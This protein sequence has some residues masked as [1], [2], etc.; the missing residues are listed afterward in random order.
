MKT[1]FSGMAVRRPSISRNR[2]ERI[3]TTLAKERFLHL[4]VLPCVVWLI[5]F[6]YVPMSGLLIAF[7]NYR[8]NTSGFLGIFEAPW[9]GLRNFESFFN[10]IYFTRLMSNTL[11]ISF[12]R[13]IF[14]FPAAILFALLLNEIR[15]VH[16]KKFVQTVSYM[17][18]FLSWVVISALATALLSPDAGAVNGLLQMLGHDKIFFLASEQWFRPVLV[19]SGTWQGIGWSSIVYLAAISG[20]PQEQYESARLDGANKLQQIWYI[21]LPGIKEIIAVMLIMQVGRAMT[22]NFEQVFNMYSPA[23]YKV[24]DIFDT[25][26]YRSGITDANFSYSAAVGLFK[27]VCSLIL[28]LMTN[29]ITN[30]LDAGGLW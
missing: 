5:L 30:K 26:V 29:T 16:F 9:I 17:P 27:S 10:S 7:K 18:H 3:K 20:L 11:A 21:T 6:K 1:S 2:L 8:G 15:R 28:V 19:I 25:Y 22:D 24:A 14:S 13:L 23:V 4:M 12:L